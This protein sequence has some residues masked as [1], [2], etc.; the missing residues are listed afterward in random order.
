MEFIV[1]GEQKIKTIWEDLLVVKICEPRPEEW[2]E[3]LVT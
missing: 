2:E 1:L 3:I